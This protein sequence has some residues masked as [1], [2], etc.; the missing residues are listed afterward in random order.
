MIFFQ[1]I[2]YAVN[3]L[4]CILIHHTVSPINW[5]YYLLYLTERFDPLVQTCCS[6]SDKNDEPE[7]VQAIRSEIR[8]RGGCTHLQV[9]LG[10]SHQGNYI[11]LSL[12]S[13]PKYV[14]HSYI[15]NITI[16]PLQRIYISVHYYLEIAEKIFL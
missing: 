6:F 11:I 1:Q 7:K 14:C 12:L 3:C 15:D 13:C 10:L 9:F 8:G 16:D 2:D 4:V 5:I